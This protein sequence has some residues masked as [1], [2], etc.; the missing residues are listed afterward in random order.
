[1]HL[2]DIICPP[3]SELPSMLLHLFFSAAKRRVH[4]LHVQM[5]LSPECQDSSLK[6]E[7]QNP[8]RQGQKSAHT[9]AITPHY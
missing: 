3:V 5:I 2:E 6:A 4:G 8:S 1:M 7:E 9:P